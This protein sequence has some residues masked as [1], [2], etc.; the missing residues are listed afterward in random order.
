MIVPMVR[1]DD[2]V[3]FALPLRSQ[4]VNGRLEGVVGGGWF[5]VHAETALGSR[6]SQN[7]MEEDG[8]E[9]PIQ[10]VSTGAASVRAILDQ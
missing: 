3:H 7:A 9:I 1:R 6:I 8:I 10:A 2:V 4:K 5:S